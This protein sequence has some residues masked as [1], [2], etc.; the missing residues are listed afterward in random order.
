MSQFTYIKR[1]FQLAKLAGNR[2][3][4]NPRVGS[5]IVHKNQ[6]LGEGYHERFGEAHAE[7]NALESITA[8]NK[9]Y[10][11]QS[12]LYVSLEPCNHQG[13]TPPCTIAIRDAGIPEVE[14]AAVDPSEKISGSG[15][16][17]LESM[18]INVITTE[19][20]PF[21]E[22]PHKAFQT[23][24]RYG[25][26][27]IILKFAQSKDGFMGKSDEQVWF[28][29]AWSKRLVHQW[30]SR[31]SAILVGIGTVLV[32]N[33]SLTTR[34]GY[35]Q[36]PLRIVPDFNHRLDPS[37]NIFSEETPVWVISKTTPEREFSLNHVTRKLIPKGLELP[38]FLNKELFEAGINTLLVEG[39]K[40]ILS[41]YIASKYWDEIRVFTGSKKLS[42]GIPSP[43]L[44]GHKKYKDL[45]ILGDRLEIFLPEEKG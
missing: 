3:T 35:G 1:A 19:K 7:V 13:K 36:N 5:V 4:P 15:I 31:T 44:S 17:D 45:D 8:I 30:R 25:R 2:C 37:M 22:I 10:L 38:E 23:V 26:P 39:G 11:A 41:S 9:K 6:I 34:F 24:E 40:K 27:R 42:S 33:P 18:G 32:D 29:N 43:L 21:V 12:K 16:L 14:V 20:W 28:T